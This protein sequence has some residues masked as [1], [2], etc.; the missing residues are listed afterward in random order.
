MWD[1]A[2]PFKNNAKE[3]G[4]C[5]DYFHRNV[6]CRGKWRQAE[7]VNAG[8][9]L[10]I[11]AVLFIVKV[12]SVTWILTNRSG[13]PRWTRHLK[14]H[15]HSNGASEEDRRASRRLIGDNSNVVGEEYYNDPESAAQNRPLIEPRG[16]E[17]GEG[18]RVEPSQL[19]EN[20]S[21]WRND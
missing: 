7:Q 8:L 4:N 21:E 1:R 20:G 15:S 6:S 12:L 13:A 14:W 3:G 17:E 10:L 18:E 19:A 11:A 16:N 5:A 9:L 2:W